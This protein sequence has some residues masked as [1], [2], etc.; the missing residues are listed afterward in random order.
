MIA[1][2]VLIVIMTTRTGVAGIPFVS[3]PACHVA[4]DA[5]RKAADWPPFLVECFPTDK[6]PTK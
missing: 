4:R 2:W 5:I 1:E 6:R 3:A